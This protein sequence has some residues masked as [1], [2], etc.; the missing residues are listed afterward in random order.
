M[1]QLQVSAAALPRHVYSAS[2][3]LAGEWAEHACPLLLKT[4]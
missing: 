4:T 1:Q 2:T 3:Q